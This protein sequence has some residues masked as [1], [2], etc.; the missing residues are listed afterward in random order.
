[1]YNEPI[2]GCS[3]TRGIYTNVSPGE[4]AKNDTYLQRKQGNY[5][6]KYN[7]ILLCS[8]GEIAALAS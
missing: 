4:T 8:L 2:H 1:M 6:S 5:L 7:L 3:I